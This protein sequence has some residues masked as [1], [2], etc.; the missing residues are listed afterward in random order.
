M[1]D[2]V[3]RCEYVV[4]VPP[5]VPGYP[6]EASLVCPE[7]ATVVLTITDLVY[8]DEHERVAFCDRHAADI[9]GHDECGLLYTVT[10]RHPIPEWIEKA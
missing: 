7:P 2:S 9:E 3:Q 8:S 1:T 4:D 6:E 10:A 5:M